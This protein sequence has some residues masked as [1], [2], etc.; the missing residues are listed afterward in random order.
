MAPQDR[1]ALF[2][3]F[4]DPFW[5]AVCER[6]RAKHVQASRTVFG[7]KPLDADMYA[8]VC[9]SWHTLRFSPALATGRRIEH[10]NP[11]RRQ[12][13]V[14]KQ[15][16]APRPSTQAQRTLALQRQEQ[17][18]QGR[19][20]RREEKQARVQAQFAQKQQKKQQK[21]TGR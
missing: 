2:V 3:Y 10:T 17:K 8:L 20:R 4:E 16:Q 7:A 21:H 14:Q 11:K 5:V 6:E 13:E 15:V 18:Q 19:A 9:H 1:I 12:R